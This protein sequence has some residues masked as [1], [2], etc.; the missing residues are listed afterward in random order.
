[1]LSLSLPCPPLPPPAP[2]PSPFLARGSFPM[3]QSDKKGEVAAGR[4][5]SRNGHRTCLSVNH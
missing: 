2:C 5:V 4:I 1:M 3:S